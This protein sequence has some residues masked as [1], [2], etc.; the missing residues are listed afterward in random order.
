[1]PK[2]LIFDTETTGKWD[3]KAPDDASHQPHLVQLAAV[4]ED[5]DTGA[6]LADVNLMVRPEEWEIEEGA[7]K[8]HGISKVK[9]QACG[10]NLPNA[11]F[12]F[13]DLVEQANFVVA[14]NATFDI[15]I[16]TRALREADVPEIP[17]SKRPARCTMLTST[18]I[19]KVPGPRGFKWPSLAEAY[20]FFFNEDFDNAHDAKADMEAC[21]RIH[22]ALIQRG[23]F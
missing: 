12:V 21:R 1:M 6:T 10:V 2:G 7:Q 22:R 16:M 8:V 17:W 14:H 13:R 20:R 19:C 15:R 4:L 11:C 23:A 9:A 5:V 3:F 18:P